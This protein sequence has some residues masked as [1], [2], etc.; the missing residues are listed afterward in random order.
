MFQSWTPLRLDLIFKK[1]VKTDDP[2]SPYDDTRISCNSCHIERRDKK[3]SEWKCNH[4]RSTHR[5]THDIASEVCIASCGASVCISRRNVECGDSS[6]DLERSQCVYNSCCCLPQEGLTLDG[7]MRGDVAHQF[8]LLRRS[9]LLDLFTIA[10]P[11]GNHLAQSRDLFGRSHPLTGSAEI[12]P[13]LQ[14]GECL[15][16]R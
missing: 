10:V 7:C 3:Q 11:D 8:E 1:A 16:G 2:Q 13:A 9:S 5:A 15:I 4:F 14:R 12:N 6:D